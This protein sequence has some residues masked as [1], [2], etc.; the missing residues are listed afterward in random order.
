MQEISIFRAFIKGFHRMVYS[1]NKPV[2]V[3]RTGEKRQS[4]QASQND[5]TLQYYAK[6]VCA[7]KI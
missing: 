1:T 4:R 3:A 7:G 6:G 5:E 2:K